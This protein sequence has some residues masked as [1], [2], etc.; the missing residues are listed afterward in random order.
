M[1]DIYSIPK[2][3]E[4]VLSFKKDIGDALLCASRINHDN[5][6]VTLLRAASIVRKDLFS[7]KHECYKTDDAVREFFSD[8][9]L[10][11]RSATVCYCKT[12]PVVMAI[13]IR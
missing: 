9:C 8:P 5:E 6:A 1:V 3:Y 4:V 13:G 12:D 7:K 2:N 10:N 11:C